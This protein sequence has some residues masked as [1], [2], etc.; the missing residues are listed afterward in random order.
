MADGVS[1]NFT[2]EEF[3]KDAQRVPCDNQCRIPR[4]FMPSVKLDGLDYVKLV[5][6]KVSNAIRRMGVN[7]IVEDE[8]RDL[9][10][11]YTVSLPSSRGFSRLGEF[12]L[13]LT[14]TM[15][16]SGEKLAQLAINHLQ[17][18]LK[19]MGI[20]VQIEQDVTAPLYVWFSVYISNGGYN[21]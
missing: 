20:D 18:T 2:I 9:S 5:L 10:C 16:Q 3:L 21:V 19:R 13:T 11:V 17:D 4:L 6:D 1:K 14:S 7:I 12:R 15:I 8:V